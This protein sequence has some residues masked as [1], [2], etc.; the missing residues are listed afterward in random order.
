MTINAPFLNPLENAVKDVERYVATRGWDQP[1]RLFALVRTA[2]SLKASPELA[3]I[4]PKEAVEEAEKNPESLTAIEQEDLPSKSTLEELLGGIEFGPAVA[5]AAAV[6]ERM[7]VPPEAE[8]GLP[9]DVDEA[10]EVLAA[11]PERQDVRLV[12][13][14][15]RDGS[16]SCAVR[17]RANDDENMVSFGDNLVPGL[18]EALASTLSS[19]HRPGD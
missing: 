5:G 3:S 6:V 10:L 14:V 18:V 2:D 12:A 1:V 16:S 4:L 13:A 11:H 19:V 17:T 7:I 15:L 8:R 9:E